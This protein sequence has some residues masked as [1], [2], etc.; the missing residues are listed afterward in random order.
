MLMS[1][2][3]RCSQLLAKWIRLQVWR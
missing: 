3:V 1:H 2:A